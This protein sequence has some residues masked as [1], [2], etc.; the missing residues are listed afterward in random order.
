M[1]LYWNFQRGW[2]LRGDTDDKG[3][4]QIHGRSVLETSSDLQIFLRD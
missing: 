2:Q 3:D 1:N 4:P